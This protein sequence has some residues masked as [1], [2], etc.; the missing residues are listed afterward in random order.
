MHTPG[1]PLK[2]LAT[3]VLVCGAAGVC[4][5]TMGEEQ[6]MP[7]D[8]KLNV[9]ISVDY[10]VLH[11]ED[12]LP[13]HRLLA[14]RMKAVRYHYYMPPGPGDL[15]GVSVEVEDDHLEETMEV[16]RDVLEETKTERTL[17]IEKL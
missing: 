6:V 1:T 17:N 9:R 16:F 15:G 2:F 3:A 4:Y 10:S 12:P 5:T 11:G 14:E 8:P 7:R 13:S